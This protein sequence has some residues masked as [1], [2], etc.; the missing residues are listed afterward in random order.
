[1]DTNKNNNINYQEVD[2]SL[3][4]VS[5]GVLGVVAKF[6]SPQQAGLVN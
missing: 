4:T 3:F 1:M 2:T 5:N 6:T